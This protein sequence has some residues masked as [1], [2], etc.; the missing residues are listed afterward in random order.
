MFIRI[1]AIIGTIG[2]SVGP[3]VE[4]SEAPLSS[5]D[6]LAASPLTTQLMYETCDVHS[7]SAV[8]AHDDAC[9]MGLTTPWS[10]A[11]DPK[12]RDVAHE[13]SDAKPS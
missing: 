8:V 13:L 10:V 6:L 12:R 3:T 5:R 7:P 4:A 1:G 2:L 11:L 9:S